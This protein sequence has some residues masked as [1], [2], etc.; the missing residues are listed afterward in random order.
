MKRDTGRNVQPMKH[1]DSVV[2]SHDAANNVN[3]S[4]QTK[5]VYFYLFLATAFCNQLPTLR[6]FTILPRES[7]RWLLDISNMLTGD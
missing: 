4:Q 2:I 3:Q 6:Q 1:L 7:V 5:P